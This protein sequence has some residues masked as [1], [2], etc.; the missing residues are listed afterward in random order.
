TAQFSVFAWRRI[1]VFPR[2]EATG[3]VLVIGAAALLSAY[4]LPPARLA[5]AAQEASPAP[6]TAAAVAPGGAVTLGAHAGSVLV[7][8]TLSP[9]K[10]GRN[11]LT[12]YVQSLDGPDATA[13]L[14]VRA[15]AS[16]SQ[17]SPP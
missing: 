2:G 10:P 1:A 16:G 8:L 6:T 17:V 7:G 15:T 14:P 4:P 5:E 13:G 12:I 11:E 9:G 3:V